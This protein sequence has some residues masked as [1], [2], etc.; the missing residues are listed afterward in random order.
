VSDWVTQSEA[1]GKRGVA[2]NVVNNWLARGRLKHS[3]TQFGK[4]LVSLSEVLS[5]EPGSG[6]WPKGRSRKGS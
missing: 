3:K 4:R 6:G 2:V 1:A 5:Y